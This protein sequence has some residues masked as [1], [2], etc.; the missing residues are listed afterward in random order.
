MVGGYSSKNPMKKNGTVYKLY[1][2]KGRFKLG[3]KGNLLQGRSCF[4]AVIVRNCI[5]V[6]GGHLTN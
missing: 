2:E 1:K 3:K 4:G 5:Y 6:I